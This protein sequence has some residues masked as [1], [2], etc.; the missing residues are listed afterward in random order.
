MLWT[1]FTCYLLTVF[2]CSR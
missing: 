2:F 1:F